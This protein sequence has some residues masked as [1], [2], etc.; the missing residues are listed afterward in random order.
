MTDTRQWRAHAAALASQIAQHGELG[1]QW[2]RVVEQV[3][4]HVFVPRIWS[5]GDPAEAITTGDPRWLELVYSDETLVTQRMT[6]PGQGGFAWATSS[7]TRPGF[8]IR[9]LG[10]LDVADGMRVLEIG[11][12]TGYGAALLSERLGSD[13]VTSIDIDPALVDAARER[14]AAAGY[15]PVLAVGDGTA[16]YPGRAPYDRVIATVANERV[17]YTWVEQTRPGGVILAD[18]RPRGMTRAG[19][20]ARLVVGGDGTAAGRLVASAGYMSMRRA[21]DLPGIPEAPP[22][23]ATTVRTRPSRLGSEVLNVP[24]LSL[25]IWQ[26]IPGVSA[27]GLPGDAAQ[28]VA[29]DGSW[30]RVPADGPGMV[31]YGG[32]SDVWARVEDAHAWWTGH[33]RPGVEDFGLTITPA[34]HHW[35]FQSPDIPVPAAASGS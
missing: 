29:G 1:D 30:A 21:V 11:T 14:L 31:E 16:G 34:A 24:G 10:L 9:M 3:P 15:A 22:I 35:W 4:R 12:G 8:M 27:F 25:L 19:A 17:P 20:L 26:H 2:R 33:G 32:P 6:F 5:D 28:V 18:L 13:L 23:D 7:S